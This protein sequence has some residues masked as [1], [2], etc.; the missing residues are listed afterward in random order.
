MRK[1]RDEGFNLWK[2]EQVI[3]IIIFLFGYAKFMIVKS[4]TCIYTKLYLCVYVK[5]QFYRC[6]TL[7]FAIDSEDHVESLCRY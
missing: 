4:R 7:G 6:R 2:H 1:K 3:E 5:N